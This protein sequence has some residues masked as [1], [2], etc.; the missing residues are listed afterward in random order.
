MSKEGGHSYLEIVERTTYRMGMQDRYMDFRLNPKWEVPD[1][2]IV[3]IAG[4]G[5]FID[6]ELNPNQPVT[7]EEARKAIV[8]CVDM[9]AIAVHTHARGMK[10]GLYDPVAARTYLHNVLD[11]LRRKYGDN[12]VTDGGIGYYGKTMK[13]NLS[14]VDERLY[15]TVILNP[16][17]GQM[18][19]YI[20]VYSPRVVQEEVKYVQDRGMKILVDIHDTAHIS[21]AKKWLIDTG[22]LQKPYFWHVLG[23]V[24]GGFIHMGSLKGMIDGLRFIV[25][26]IREIDDDSIIYVSQSG[27]ASRYL[28]ALSILMG[29]HVR[30]GMEDTIWKWPHKDEKINSNTEEVKFAIDFARSLGREPVTAQEYRKMVGLRR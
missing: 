5:V 22:L 30:I 7:A 12:I 21:N 11:P 24:D 13:E 20:R 19:D 28:I 4:Y 6:K 10:G 16:S 2:I 1:K 15:E 23:P 26:R 29:L 9:G 17:V 18:G 25:D 3:G 27:R 14:F 8:P